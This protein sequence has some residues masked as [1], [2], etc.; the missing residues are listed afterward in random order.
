MAYP[1]L[2]NHTS[3]SSCRT[4]LMYFDKDGLTAEGFTGFRSFAELTLS[5]IPQ[6]PG[7]YAVLM[8]EGFAPR[9]L[10]GSAH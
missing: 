9:I 10:V 5:E 8:P 3:A 4:N 7:I 6:V 2:A 1:S